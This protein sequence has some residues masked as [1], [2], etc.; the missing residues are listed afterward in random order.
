MSLLEYQDQTWVIGVSG[1]PD[2]MALLDMAYHAKVLC[3]V[4]HVNYH[5]RDSANRDQQVV[6]AYCRKNDIPLYVY[7]AYQTN[8]GNFQAWA[9]DYRYSK[10]KE[11][12]LNHHGKGIMVGHHLDDHIETF[13]MQEQRKSLASYYGLQ[14]STNHLGIN[15]L[16]PLLSYS[17]QDLINYCHQKDITF[18]LDESND[19]L[20]YTRNSV[21]QKLRSISS[22]KTKTILEKIIDLN[23]THQNMLNQC[24]HLLPLTEIK[25]SD[26]KTQ[27][28]PTLFLFE[29]IKQ[30]TSLNKISLKYLNEIHRQIDS[31]N[32]I[33]I[34]LDRNHRFIKQYDTLSILNK[35]KAYHYT[36]M[37][38]DELKTPYFR[39]I[40]ANDKQVSFWLSNEDFPLQI[41]DFNQ[42][43]AH[44]ESP[45]VIKMRRY[46]IKHKIPLRQREAWPI[47]LN[48][49]NQLIYMGQRTIKSQSCTNTVALFMIK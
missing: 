39:L 10:M 2:S 42:Y 34:Q 22:D 35:P 20:K 11:C 43:A 41:I 21:R 45:E 19:D 16:R 48:K 36:Y 9:R 31:S 26:Y 14:A 4:V 1:G 7:D 33:T 49:D 47:V 37:L 32:K 15:L 28:H 30:H 27:S 3:I 5:K 23:E 12:V 18:G 25:L 29:W 17:K 6:E 46:F 38:Y 44:Y 13:V 40:P 8:K 24:K